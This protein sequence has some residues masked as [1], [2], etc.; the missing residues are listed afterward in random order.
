[1]FRLAR[2]RC[3]AG[4]RLSAATPAASPC[5][6]AARRLPSEA[7]WERAARGG[8]DGLP[9][10]WGSEKP[11]DASRMGWWAN[12]WQGR[13]PSRNEA[14]DGFERTAPVRSYRP[15]PVYAPAPVYD[16]PEPVYYPGHPQWRH[17]YRAA[18]VPV[19]SVPRYQPAWQ[20]AAYPRHGDGRWERRDERRHDRRED[21]R[22]DRH[23]RRD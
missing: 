9:Y 13:F 18:P 21:R 20:P 23:D 15:E 19:V 7:E 8:V 22:D 10:V 6:W 5:R 14:T 4:A 1:M 16:A 17:Q 3:Y 12:I 2:T 11:N